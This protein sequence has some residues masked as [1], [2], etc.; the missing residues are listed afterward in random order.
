MDEN[1][2]GKVSIIGDLTL[3]RDKVFNNL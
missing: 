3:T 1:E 2:F